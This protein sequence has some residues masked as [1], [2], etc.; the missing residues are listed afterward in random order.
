MIRRNEEIR[1][2][3]RLV[4]AGVG[5]FSAILL[6]IVALLA[7]EFTIQMAL[8]AVVGAALAFGNFFFTARAVVQ[9]VDQ[10]DIAQAIIRRSYTWRMAIIFAVLA[11]GFAAQWIWWFTATVPFIFPKMSLY[12]GEI[13][14]RKGHPKGEG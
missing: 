6:L 9:A 3:L 5:F 4:G 2:Q 11:I 7:D 12:L 10:P 13:L 8:G 14:P 1:R